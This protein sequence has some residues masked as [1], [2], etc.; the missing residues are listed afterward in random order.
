MLWSSDV[1]ARLGPGFWGL[2]LNDE[3]E[4]A[5]WSDDEDLSST[6]QRLEPPADLPSAL[7]QMQ[8]L[9]RKLAQA[10]RDMAEYRSLIVKANGLGNV[11]T[12]TRGKV[13]EISLPDDVEHVDI[14]I[15][16]WMGYALLV[17]P[18]HHTFLKVLPVGRI[19]LGIQLL[20]FLPIGAPSSPIPPSAH[21]PPPS[22]VTRT[23]PV[24]L[25]H[26]I[27]R[28][29]LLKQLTRH[30]YLVLAEV[31]RQHNLSRSRLLVIP[32]PSSR[33]LHRVVSLPAILHQI[34]GLIGRRAD[35]IP[36]VRPTGDDGPS[37]ALLDKVRAL[38]AS[39][40]LGALRTLDLRGNDLRN[41]VTYLAQVLTRNRTL[42]VLNLS[43]NKLGVQCLVAVAEALKYNHCL[44]TLDLSRISAL[45]LVIRAGY[46]IRL[47][48]RLVQHLVSSEKLEPAPLSSESSCRAWLPSGSITSPSTA[49][50]RFPSSHGLHWQYVEEEES[51]PW[52]K[53]RGMM[54]Q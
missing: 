35:F 6:D 8:F 46:T 22:P 16:E 36:M 49:T 38:D 43:D 20:K 31:L 7:R 3:L 15:S 2:G 4:M 14:T 25:L 19:I 28:P 10:H 33:H 44:E 13:E 53:H 51:E 21:L 40:R 39:P 42:K 23:G 45:A 18:N 27:H 17:L 30:M 47:Y 34:P 48:D 24:L 32:S 5:D 9:E 26:A 50:T 52:G 37:T 29:C 41:G 12:V 11:I 1:Q 54:E